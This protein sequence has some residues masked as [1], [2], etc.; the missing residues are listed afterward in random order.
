MTNNKLSNL[1][2]KWQKPGGGGAPNTLTLQLIKGY[3]ET[4]SHIPQYPEFPSPSKKNQILIEEAGRGKRDVKGGKKT[5][6][7]LHLLLQL[8][9]P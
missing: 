1:R 4:T 5:F 6:E 8:I 9:Q 3:P 2:V 7:H